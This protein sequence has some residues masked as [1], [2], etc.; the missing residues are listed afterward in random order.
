M[1]TIE[2]IEVNESIKKDFSPLYY[3]IKK[4]SNVLYLVKN[5]G[6]SVTQM[7]LPVT[8]DLR[9]HSSWL[10]DMDVSVPDQILYIFNHER[11]E[12]MIV[13]EKDIKVT[14]VPK[15]YSDS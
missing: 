11:C 13:H 8:Q 10:V 15:N 14:L 3:I 2:M 4:D 5:E 1:K 6:D 7:C 9:F 12:K